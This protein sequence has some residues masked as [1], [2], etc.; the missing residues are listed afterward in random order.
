MRALANGVGLGDQRGEGL[1]QFAWCAEPVVVD[2]EPF[3]IR[4]AGDNSWVLRPALQVEVAAEPAVVQ[5]RAGEATPGA[6]E[7][8]GRL[9]DG[10]GEGTAA[11]TSATKR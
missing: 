10:V 8:D 7:R 9:G 2:I 1:V 11:S 6:L 4:S 3:R 5:G